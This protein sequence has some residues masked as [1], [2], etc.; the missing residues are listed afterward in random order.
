MATMVAAS[1]DPTLRRYLRRF[2]GYQRDDNTDAS[3]MGLAWPFDVVADDDNLE[4]TIAAIE[5][6]LCDELGVRRYQFDGYEGAQRP[7]VELGVADRA[8]RIHAIRMLVRREPVLDFGAH[9]AEAGGS[10]HTT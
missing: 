9:R 4:R 10:H 5:R 3:P 7:N 6:D 1:P 8:G 2:G